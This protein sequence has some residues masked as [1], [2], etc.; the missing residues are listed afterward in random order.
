VTFKE[1]PPERIQ[2]HEGMLLSPQHFQQE[3]AR[4]DA[5]L[6]WHGLIANPYGWGVRTL[7][8]DQGLLATGLLR[9]TALDVVMPDGTAVVLSGSHLAGGLEFDLLP[10]SESL[11]Q[12]PMAVYLTMG[13][14]RSMRDPGQPSR[15]KATNTLPVEDEVS[16]A[17][18][19]DVP[20]MSANL[21]LMA[22]DV[23]PSVLLHLQIL[24]VQKDNEV[25]K[26]G[27]YMPALLEVSP[28][29]PLKS[30]AQML[31]AQM[32]S[33]A[34][35]LAK[36]TAVPSSRIEDRLQMLE[37]RERLAHL[38]AMLPLL[39]AVLRSP[40]ITPY[41]LFLALC[42]QLGGLSM[43]RPGAVPFMPPPWDHADPWGVFEPLLQSVEDS[44]GEV[45]QDWRTRVF[46]F[47]EGV[48]SLD[49]DPQWLGKT[50]VIGLRGPSERE[51]V[52]WMA[53]AVIGSETVWTSLSDRRVLGAARQRIEEAPEL[54]VRSSVGYT[55]FSIDVSSE[56]IV[57][58]QAL[59]ISNANESRS[60]TRPQELVLFTKG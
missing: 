42:A 14:N 26:L 8:I 24:T 5:L 60:A 55:L 43:L 23:P 4:V 54:G 50:L 38:S 51:L 35:F 37:Q 40:V 53:S 25:F 39:E 52:S 45:S 19:V 31:A 2:W 1:P 16:E 30:R 48:F 49:M 46:A 6:A 17:L 58:A 28:G 22:G 59:V 9:V 41:A 10:F 7:E 21:A 56:T 20:R 15:F 12:G 18:P 32:R 29:S 44:V 11:E 34:A 33:K 57:A 27:A 3:S 47:K 36:Q 13:R